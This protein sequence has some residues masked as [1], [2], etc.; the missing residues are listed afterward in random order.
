MEKAIAYAV[1]EIKTKEEK[2]IKKNKKKTSKKYEQLPDE[3]CNDLIVKLEECKQSPILHSTL[4]DRNAG[5][6]EAVSEKNQTERC[7]VRQS[8]RRFIQ[9]ENITKYEI[10]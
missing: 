3:C 2:K 7:L 8:L 9:E 6:R 5:R 4:P 10:L 1:E